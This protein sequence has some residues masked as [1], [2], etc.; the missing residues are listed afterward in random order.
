MVQYTTTDDTT[1]KAMTRKMN[2]DGNKWPTLWQAV[3]VM[4][5]LRL[6]LVMK[7]CLP[8][9]KHYNASRLRLHE[10]CRVVLRLSGTTWKTAGIAAIDAICGILFVACLVIA[11]ILA[12][13]CTDY[14]WIP[15]D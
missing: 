13:A 1:R 14:N 12:W 8:K 11:F 2:H 4:L 15:V 6:P 9:R 3:L 7:G 5:F 10:R